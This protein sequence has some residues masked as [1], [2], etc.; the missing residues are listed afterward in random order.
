VAK[1]HGFKLEFPCYVS[2]LT[3]ISDRNIPNIV[4]KTKERYVL[5]PL[6]SC[7]TCTTSFDLWMFRGGHDT[8]SMVVSFINNLWKHTYVTVGIFEMH[9]IADVAMAN[10]VKVLLDSFGLLTKSLLMSKTKGLI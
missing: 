10:Q 7:V 8:F 3:S 6:A 2:I 5:L 1:A 9:N 4:E